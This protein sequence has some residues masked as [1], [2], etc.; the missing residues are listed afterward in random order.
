MRP[1]TVRKR[2]WSHDT[3]IVIALVVTILLAV[4]AI[5]LALLGVGRQD[6]PATPDGRSATPSQPISTKAAEIVMRSYLLP[7]RDSPWLWRGSTPGAHDLNRYRN[8]QIT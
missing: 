7:K 2:R 8:R 3:L 5:V 4:A 1:A 6:S